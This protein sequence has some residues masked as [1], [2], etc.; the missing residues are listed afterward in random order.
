MTPQGR[1]LLLDDNG[2]YTH[3]FCRKDVMPGIPRGVTVYAVGALPIDAPGGVAV[4]CG[5]DPTKRTVQASE[6]SAS[7]DSFAKCV[8]NRVAAGK[9]LHFHY[10]D[11]AI[12]SDARLEL[13]FS[14][15]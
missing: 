4:N 3:Q 9:P 12:I 5:L 6:A 14:S 15:K 1:I 2:K 11:D 10:G 8:R 13:V 7:G